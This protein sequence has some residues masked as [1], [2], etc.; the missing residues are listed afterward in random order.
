MCVARL[1]TT[2]TARSFA[3][4]RRTS[5]DSCSSP[6]DIVIDGEIVAYDTMDAPRSTCCRTIAAPARAL[7]Y[8]FALLTLRGKDLT[9]STRKAAGS[10]ARRANAALAGAMPTAM[11]S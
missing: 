8:A 7:L 2:R 11:P 9:G 6:D 4:Q 5:S 1:L 3:V 10:F